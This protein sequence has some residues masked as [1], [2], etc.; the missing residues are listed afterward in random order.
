M[1]LFIA[2]VLL[3]VVS[4]PILGQEK[5]QN[6]TNIEQPQM[7]SIAE[8]SIDGMAC[9]EGCADKISFN[10]KQTPG[11]ITAEVSYDRK[12]AI[13]QFNPKIIA[14]S[15]LE[16]VITSTKVKAYVYTINSITIKE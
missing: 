9:Q 10:L 13:I 3:F 7:T 1:K 14:P 12:E 2:V 4:N 16:T 6:N 15:A 11:V 8:I 5:A